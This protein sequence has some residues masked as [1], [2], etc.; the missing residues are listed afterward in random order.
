MIGDKMFYKT[1][2]KNLFVDTFELKLWDGSSEIYG[3]GEPKFK[4]IF[5][6]PIP[7]ADIIKDPSIA[8]GE[9]YM[10]KK[11]D[12]EGSIQDVI[13][14]LYNSK[15]S[16]LGN[17]KYANLIKMVKNNIKNSKKNIEFHYDV[18]NDFYKLWLD[19]TMTYSCGYF[20]SQNDSLTD[21]QK[22][23]VDHILKKLNLKEGETLLDIGCGWGELII[24]AAKKYKVKAMGVTLSTQQFEKVK[25]RIE[26]EGLNELVEVELT[27]YREIKNRKF[28]RVVSVGMLEH[29]GKDNLSEYFSAVKELLNDKG[30]SL[31]HCITNTSDS[32]TNSWINKYIFPGG[33]VPSIQ[34]LVNYMSEKNFNVID[35]ENLRLHYGKTLECWASNFENAM[36]EI[37][38]MK[39]E[40]FIRMWRMYLNSC[41]ASFNC[42]NIN[43]HQFLFTKGVN[44]DLPWTREYMYK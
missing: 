7:K 43:L 24:T 20:K 33:Y 21:A 17:E 10:T 34:E 8:F 15:E 40:T 4:I 27:D 31:L 1:L 2:F 42:G 32:G 18:G 11:L 41:A 3:E 16:F 44:N 28:D 14:S 38:K 5:N 26:S 13:E 39:D 12:I 9:G 30:V 22:N 29:V 19:D 36:P 6:E 23:K 25:K 37:E 35:V